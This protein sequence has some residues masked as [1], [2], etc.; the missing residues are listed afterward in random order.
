MV[1]LLIRNDLVDHPHRMGVDAFEM[2]T[3]FGKV[4]Q[5][6][7]FNCHGR[8]MYRPCSKQT[9]DQTKGSATDCA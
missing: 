6:N 1:L 5:N 4:L 8:C 9:S 2:R 3:L 7:A